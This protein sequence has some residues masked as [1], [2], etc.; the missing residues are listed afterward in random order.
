MWEWLRRDPAYVAW[1][2]RAST[3]TRGAVPPSAAL[4]RWGG[5]L[6]PR[7]RGSARPPHGSCG[8]RRLIPARC[9]SPSRRSPVRVPTPSTST[10]SH[11][12]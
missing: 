10:G 8:T 5:A 2:T 1:Y 11:R 7:T 6:S 9:P 4:L 12:G 3:A